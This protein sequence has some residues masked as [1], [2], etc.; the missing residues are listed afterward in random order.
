MQRRRVWSR[1]EKE[2]IGA[3]ELEPGAVASEVAP[4]GVESPDRPSGRGLYAIP[5]SEDVL[6]A[7]LYERI[8][9]G[10]QIVQ[11]L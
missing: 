4:A 9:N 7:L 2:R 11:P 3:A 8:V 1:A 6:I 10:K 5:I